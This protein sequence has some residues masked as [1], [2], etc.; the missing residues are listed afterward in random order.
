MPDAPE[1]L[2]N[3]ILEA[4][5]A[6]NASQVARKLG[7]AKQ[8]VYE[9]EKGKLPALGTLITIARSGNVSLDWLVLGKGPKKP[10]AQ[11][12]SEQRTALSPE[13]KTEIRRLV[14]EV[15]GALL[16]SSE[17]RRYTDAL[18][19]DLRRQIQGKK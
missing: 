10:A 7:L 4:L 3:R 2:W 16:L 5:E 14:I 9:W 8:S 13:I 19:D 12:K 6:K 11:S 15:V 17:D 1:G 18:L